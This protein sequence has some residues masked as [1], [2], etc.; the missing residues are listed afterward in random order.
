M[1]CHALHKGPQGLFSYL[2]IRWEMLTHPDSIMDNR[3]KTS[4]PVAGEAPKRVE[5][6]VQALC[7]MS[8]WFPVIG[9][10]PYFGNTNTLELMTD[11]LSNIDSLDLPGATVESVDSTAYVNEMSQILSDKDTYFPFSNN[12]T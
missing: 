12:S 3:L 8:M 9:L 1:E 2:F 4:I 7:I 6:E 10:N 5:G 11:I